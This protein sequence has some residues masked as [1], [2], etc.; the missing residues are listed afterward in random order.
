MRQKLE[1]SRK[2]KQSEVSISDFL[3]GANLDDELP[4]SGLIE[5]KDVHQQRLVS[6]NLVW[7]SPQCLESNP[8]DKISDDAK[9]VESWKQ[10]KADI[11]NVLQRKVGST[12]LALETVPVLR[13]PSIWPPP[14]GSFPDKALRHFRESEKKGIIVCLPTN[15]SSANFPTGDGTN[16]PE[17]Q[18]AKSAVFPKTYHPKGLSRLVK[19]VQKVKKRKIDKSS[20]AATKGSKKRKGVNSKKQNVKKRKG[21]NRRLKRAEIKKGTPPK[22]KGKENIDPMSVSGN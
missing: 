15:R 4:F 3:D 12:N 18:A 10:N 5:T 11:L 21:K 1:S 20:S 13:L 17:T 14:V 2:L 7:G 8:K 9:S 22:N 6:V 19:K 16:S